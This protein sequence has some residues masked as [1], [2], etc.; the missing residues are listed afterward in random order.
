MAVLDI[1]CESVGWIIAARGGLLI[2]CV[3]VIIV[4]WILLHEHVSDLN[5]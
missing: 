4:I 2:G 1:R 5:L 3:V